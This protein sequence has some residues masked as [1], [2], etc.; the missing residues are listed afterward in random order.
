MTRRGERRKRALPTR[1]A[2]CGEAGFGLAEAVVAIIV[3]GI[4]L[5]AVAGMTLSVAQQARASTYG[6]EQSM[7]SQELL[8]YH[9]DRGYSGLAAGTT[10]TTV[11]LGNRTYD[12]RIVVTDQGP[13][14]RHVEVTVSGFEDTDPTTVSSLVHKPRDIP[15]EYTP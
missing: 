5:L 6:T 10:D 2:P 7:V 13:R 1:G 9:L 15:E 8:E 4:G 14:A 11:A 12:A 3:F